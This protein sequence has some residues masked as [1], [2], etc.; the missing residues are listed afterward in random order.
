MCKVNR[1]GLCARVVNGIT[2]VVARRAVE[3]M[4]TFTERQGGVQL[5]AAELVAVEFPSPFDSARESRWIEVVRVIG[6]ELELQHGRHNRGCND[7]A[8]RRWPHSS[9]TF[10]VPLVDH[11]EQDDCHQHGERG[12]DKQKLA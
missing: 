6:K 2:C 7:D 5:A 11:D 12:Q 4:R 10:E 8:H 3:A 1:R 9:E